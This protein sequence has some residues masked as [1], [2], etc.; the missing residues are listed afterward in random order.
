MLLTYNLSKIPLDTD[1]LKNKMI[2]PKWIVDKINLSK[3]EE[4]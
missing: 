3:K 2:S 1:T 4:A